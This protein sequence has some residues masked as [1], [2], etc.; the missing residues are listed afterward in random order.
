[1][2]QTYSATGIRG[3]V[4]GETD[5]DFCYCSMY[6]KGLPN[7]ESP[8]M[9]SQDLANVILFLIEG[10]QLLD[11]LVSSIQEGARARGTRCVFELPRGVQ[12]PYSTEAELEAQRLKASLEDEAERV[13]AEQKRAEMLE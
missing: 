3:A 1:M 4:N 13:P 6:H 12:K 11:D 10:N 2:P 5:F 9:G 7:T 8:S